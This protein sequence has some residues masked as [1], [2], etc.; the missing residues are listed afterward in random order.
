M[1]FNHPFSFP[2]VAATICGFLSLSDLKSISLLNK[3]WFQLT[4]ISFEN[5]YALKIDVNSARV[6]PFNYLRDYENIKL[7]N[8]VKGDYEN[9]LFYPID[10]I[11]RLL[12]WYEQRRLAKENQKKVYR[13]NS[14]TLQECVI[15]QIVINFLKDFKEVRQIELIDCVGEGLQ[16]E[17]VCKLNLQK[18]SIVNKNLHRS[19]DDSLVDSIEKI[20]RSN[21]TTFTTLSFIVGVHET[22]AKIM[23][24]LEENS[25][26]NLKELQFL[27]G[28]WTN[29]GEKGYDFKKFCDSHKNLV[30]FLD[31]GGWF[32]NKKNLSHLKRTSPNL[33]ELGLIV[34]PSSIPFPYL[35]TLKL[36]MR[37]DEE[38][39]NSLGI[40]LP[41]VRDLTLHFKNVPVCVKDLR[42]YFKNF[43]F[44]NITK[45]DL[46]RRTTH[47][48]C[49]ALTLVAARLPNLES[50][51]YQWT[52]SKVVFKKN[53]F[54]KLK[55]LVV[56]DII[57]SKELLS[58]QGPELVDL[59][60]NHCN[61]S[62]E[63][64]QPLSTSFPKLQK[65]KIISELLDIEMVS[66]INEHF[67][68]L[69]WLDFYT[70][71]SSVKNEIR[72]LL[73]GNIAETFFR[74]PAFY[75]EQKNVFDTDIIK[76][77]QLEELGEKVNSTFYSDSK[78]F[79][80]TIRNGQQEFTILAL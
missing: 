25:L 40:V 34:D 61:F 55:T 2:D 53:V 37:D 70:A 15:N 33:K 26:P 32:L 9:F 50:L 23:K 28:L 66:E 47:D 64:I 8:H 45:L 43:K 76:E 17:T 54:R 20:I 10:A 60:I 27:F 1:D 4:Q 21:N 57:D 19:Y 49:D 59:T 78:Q 30:K 71:G 6:S 18:L 5:H 72:V 58:I 73:S 35:H 31:L 67:A 62:P 79:S 22:F 29:R 80:V 51:T 41:N 52:T 36:F 75:D 42:T 65:M 63:N 11:K 3:E 7:E 68:R 24:I 56:D 44:K 39:D 48:P 69:K 13:I 38:Y 16:S 14:L 46:C 12:N 77:L 74:C